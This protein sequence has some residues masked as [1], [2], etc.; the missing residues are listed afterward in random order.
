[1]NGK[2]FD[3]WRSCR[4]APLALPILLLS[5]GCSST[6]S[7]PGEEVRPVKTMVVTDGGEPH[8][9]SFPGRIEASKKAVLAFQVSGLIVELPVREGQKVAKGEAIAQL[10]KDEFQ[11]RLKTLKSQL[12]QARA[13]LT[14]VRAGDRPEQQMR[15]EAEVRA[16]KARLTNAHSEFERYRKLRQAKAGSQQD[17]ERAQT[18]RELA[19][20]DYQSA[21]LKLEKGTVGREEDIEAH[22][23]E[24]RGLENRVVEAKIQLDDCTLRAP[25]DG[26]VAQRFVE[27]NQNIKAKEPVVKFQDADELVVAVD[28][29]EAF[30]AGELRSADVVQMVAQFSGAP[31][32]E[33]PVHIDEVAQTADPITQTFKVRFAL[34]APPPG[35]NL[36]PGM[37]ATVVITYRRSSILG[38]RVLV[39]VAAVFKEPGGAQVVWVIG[40][41]QTALR[42]PVKIGE[43]TGGWIEIVDGLQPGE[44][45]AVAGVSFLR[46]KMKVRD[47]GDALGGG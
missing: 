1:M 22:E 31:G 35:V 3:R 6:N 4:A 8:T 38:G 5:A 28:V 10:R 7:T 2:S 44:R 18:E 23:A 24:V 16:A 27:P 34:K 25:Y 20:A 43:A 29:P 41:D 9:R 26:V 12:D 46:E 15:L 39:P 40:P 21:L 45:V 33:F 36:L 19:H 13:L 30:M 11:A 37:T 42:R 32:L 14:A 47:L 17:F